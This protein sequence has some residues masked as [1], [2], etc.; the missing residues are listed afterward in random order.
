MKLTIL[1]Y[2][3]RLYLSFFHEIFFYPFNFIIE[4]SVVLQLIKY[5]RLKKM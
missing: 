2:Y 1:F 4:N 5:S 3:D